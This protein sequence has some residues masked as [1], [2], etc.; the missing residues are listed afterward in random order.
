MKRSAAPSQKLAKKFSVP[1]AKGVG[2]SDVKLTTDDS[3]TGT[4]S[5]KTNTD[6]KIVV[7]PVQATPCPVV[8]THNQDVRKQTSP[9]DS[10]S[11]AN[12][13]SCLADKATKTVPVSRFKT[14]LMN[15]S[16][17]NIHGVGLKPACHVGQGY[18]ITGSP[19]VDCGGLDKEQK[20]SKLYFSVVWCK[21]STK[22][23]KKWEGT[24][25]LKFCKDF[26]YC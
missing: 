1:Y 22:K 23:H 17:N 18:G 24:L 16:L 20:T 13:P 12:L 6:V 14:P 3:D 7:E 26:C 25:I 9:A 5:S 15:K 2:E 4:V 8:V 21:R 11:Q 19:K 10:P